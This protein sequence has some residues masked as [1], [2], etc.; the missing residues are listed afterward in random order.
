[1]LVASTLLLMGL[2]AGQA[3]AAGD[4][5]IPGVPVGAGAISG[6]VDDVTDPHDVYCVKL[7][8]GEAVH[9]HIDASDGS[10]MFDNVGVHLIAP[11]ATS[12]HSYYSELAYFGTHPTTRPDADYTPAKDGVYYLSV[13]CRGQGMSYTITITGSAEKPPNPAY[14]RLRTSSTKVSKGHSVTLSAKL[15]DVAST[16]IPNY[17]ATL[18]RSYNGKAWTKMTSLASSTGAYSKK[19]RVTRK[20][21]F[22]MRFGGDATWSSCSSRAVTITLR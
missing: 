17:S 3:L 9:F 8:E 20:T 15:V 13:G 5:D 11:G 2:A 19:V 12:I 22:K 14:L 7:F 6:I 1:M 18:F 10:A 4:D 21:W 16:L